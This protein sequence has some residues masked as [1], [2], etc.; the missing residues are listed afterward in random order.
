MGRQGESP[1]RGNSLGTKISNQNPPL[2]PYRPIQILLLFTFPKCFHGCV[3]SFAVAMLKF[4]TKA[5][6]GRKFFFSLRVLW[7]KVYHS[8]QGIQQKHTANLPSYISSKEERVNR[9]Q[10]QAKAQSQ[11][12]LTF[13]SSSKEPS[14]V[15]IT[16][17]TTIWEPSV[18]P[19]EPMEDI[20]YSSNHNN[21]EL[22]SYLT[23]AALMT[24][25][26]CLVSEQN[27]RIYLFMAPSWFSVSK[28]Y[29]IV[30]V[31][32]NLY[33]NCCQN[34]VDPTMLDDVISHYTFAS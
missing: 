4:L 19:R 29:Q 28:F 2:H 7:H 27:E 8:K 12:L 31:W 17:P 14:E 15:P 30:Q 32:V 1:G 11:V 6:L 34:V 26:C 18:Q 10:G 3:S 16:F 33:Y 21:V 5:S 9:K 13:A 23:Q 22:A 25:S 24:S 20:L